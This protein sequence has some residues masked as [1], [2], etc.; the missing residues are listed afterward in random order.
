MWLGHQNHHAGSGCLWA[1]PEPNQVNP[2]VLGTSAHTMNNLIKNDEICWSLMGTANFL[3]SILTNR[4]DVDWLPALELIPNHLVLG[5]VRCLSL[6]LAAF[7]FMR[8]G[9]PGFTG[10]TDIE[11]LRPCL[12]CQANALRWCAHV[13]AALVCVEVCVVLCLQCACGRLCFLCVYGVLMVRRL[14]K[15]QS[16]S[17]PKASG[18]ASIPSDSYQTGTSA[19]WVCERKFW[20]WC[21][22]ID[23]CAFV[24]YV[25]IRILFCFSTCRFSERAISLLKDVN[26]KFLNLSV[27]FPG[28]RAK[29]PKAT[30]CVGLCLIVPVW[31]QWICCAQ[32]PAQVFN[33][34]RPILVF[35]RRGHR[36]HALLVILFDLI[37][38]E[39]Q[40]I[41]NAQECFANSGFLFHQ[42]CNASCRSATLSLALMIHYGVLSRESGQNYFKSR[43]RAPDEA[44]VEALLTHCL[45]W[46]LNPINPKP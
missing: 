36:R 3:W 6:D 19:H 20:V 41:A 5:N 7:A 31:F 26:I 13:D 14:T 37:M 12:S 21:W 38:K 23:L 17:K 33:L 8:W 44:Q 10:N 9:L 11:V 2:I 32:S 42:C 27:N 35:C 43:R 24:L 25:G 45:G 22:V 30:W 40:F 1:F 28:D 39:C 4:Q 18:P 16:G 29:M 34:P 15:A 46:T